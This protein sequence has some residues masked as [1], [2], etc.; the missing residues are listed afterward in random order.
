[1]PEEYNRAVLKMVIAQICQMI[2][3]HSINSTPLEFLVDLMQEYLLRISKLTKQYA[4]VRKCSTFY[5]FS[6]FNEFEPIVILNDKTKQ[7][8]RKI[9]YLWIFKTK[10]DTI[11]KPFLRIL[12]FTDC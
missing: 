1:M 2:G 6:S 8:C 9:L 12:S 11:K 3:W 5:I 10:L 7:L 4:E